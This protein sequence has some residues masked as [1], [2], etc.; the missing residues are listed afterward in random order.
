MG[1]LHTYFVSKLPRESDRE[2]VSEAFSVSDE[3]FAQTFKFKK[4]D[5]LFISHESAGL[6]SVPIPI[7]SPNAEDRIK[8]HLEGLE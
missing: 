6:D 3:M 1:Q 4:G 7:H 2:R 8:H 5:W